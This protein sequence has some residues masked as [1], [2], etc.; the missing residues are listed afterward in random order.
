MEL[1]TTGAQSRPYRLSDAALGN[2]GIPRA[3]PRVESATQLL[4]DRDTAFPA[5]IDAVE[6]AR[7]SI[8]VGQYV[9]KDEGRGGQLLEALLDRAHDADPVRVDLLVDRE[10]SM[11]YPGMRARREFD[12]LADDTVRIARFNGPVNPFRGPVYHPKLLGV[13]GTTGF[14]GSMAFDGVDWT[15]MMAKVHGPAARQLH[16]EHTA[17]W[18]AAGGVVADHQRELLRAADMVGAA[19]S[20]VGARLLANRPG[21]Y[22][23]ATD[24]LLHRMRH[25]TQRIWVETPYLGADEVAAELVAAADRGVD[26]RLGVTGPGRGTAFPMMPPLSMSYYHEL[27]ERENPVKVTQQ[28][29]MSHQKLYIIDDTADLGSVNAAKRALFD[30]VELALSSNEQT[31]V[32]QAEDAWH[33]HVAKSVPVDASDL[34]TPGMRFMGSPGGKVVRRVLG[35]I[36]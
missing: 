20:V 33:G 21:H 2:A 10:G 19:D 26:V 23:A 17:S 15:D 31:F 35:A 4:A 29:H 22:L 5:M 8:Y 30:D 11:Q 3:H 24:D 1:G 27:L 13:D 12:R 7:H 6:R 36:A 18:A 32:A 34:S 9:F 16:A 25:A 14:V 28:T